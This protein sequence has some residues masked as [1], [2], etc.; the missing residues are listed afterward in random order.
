MNNSVVE[1]SCKGMEAEGKVIEPKSFR[2]DG[3]DYFI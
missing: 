1:Y 2:W 3:G